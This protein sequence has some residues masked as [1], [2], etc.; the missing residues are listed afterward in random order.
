[1]DT[2]A[3][4]TATV[5]RAALEAV[6]A[7]PSVDVV[8]AIAVPT[9]IADL[10]TAIC[11]AA[12]GLPMAAVLLGQAESVALLP[13]RETTAAGT[14]PAG[15]RRI[16][17]YGYPE[18]AVRAIACAAGYRDWLDRDHGTVPELTGIDSDG[19][20]KLI[21]AFLTAFPRGGWLSAKD[22][23]ALL[24]S[25]Q[26]PL[27]PCRFAAD[28]AAA[29]A[30]AAEFGGHVAVKADV[31]DIVHKSAA[32]AVQLDLRTGDEV[33]A[34]VAGFDAAFGGKLRSVLVQPMVTGGVETIVGVAQ[35]PV[36][37]PLVIF[38]LGGVAT[39]VLG[40]HAARLAPLTD[41]DAAQ[42]IGE[43]RSAQLLAGYRGK[44][45]PIPAAWPTS[46]CVCRAWPRTS[47]RSLSLT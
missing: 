16:P 3:T 34:A 24:T 2:T 31:A 7:D 32:G 8:L 45:P 6:G 46:C 30:A 10:R 17:A 44:R 15:A 28:A 27:A 40:D 13:G 36:F 12:P 20:R 11:A 23:A 25:Y 41:T 26:I 43:L 35:D 19:A 37:G 33:T 39:D 22:A 18:D 42:M 9:A 38:G 5:F 1:M 29:V 4:V 21:A 14:A 47:R